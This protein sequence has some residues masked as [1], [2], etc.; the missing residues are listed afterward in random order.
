[1]AEIGLGWRDLGEMDK[2]EI[3]NKVN[4]W[5]EVRCRREI[6]NRNSIES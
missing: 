4:Q 5:E 3:A 6:E 2:R 1:M